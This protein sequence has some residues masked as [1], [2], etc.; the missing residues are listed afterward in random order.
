MTL[1]VSWAT[2]TLA[3]LASDTRTRW[4][5]L[6]DDA[7][8]ERIDDTQCKVRACAAG[9]M[10]SGPFVDWAQRLAERLADAESPNEVRARLRRWAP[11]A[12]AALDEPT[13]TLLRERQ[14]M[15]VVGST[16]GREWRLALGWDGADLFPD[17]RDDRVICVAP[18]GTEPATIRPLVDAYQAK[19]HAGLAESIRATRALFGAVHQLCGPTGAVSPALHVGIV[20]GQTRQLLGPLAVTER[21]SCVR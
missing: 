11:G 6:A 12:L 4:R 14:M 9:W 8:I 19:I 16:A 21:S 13:A 17:A 7:P 5:A 20:Q 18:N 2:P 15:L 3:L 1:L 10:A